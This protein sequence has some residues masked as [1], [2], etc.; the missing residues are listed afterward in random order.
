MRLDR[1]DAQLLRAVAVLF[2]AYLAMAVFAQAWQAI[3]QI[4]DVILI[5]IAAWALSYLLTPLVHWLDTRTVLDL[6]LSVVLVYIGIAIVLAAGGALLVPALSAQLTDLANRAPEYGDRAAQAVIALQRQLDSMGVHADITDLYGSLPVRVGE[7]AA[8]YASN[9]VGVISATAGAL[10]NV[11]L[12]LIIAFLMLIDGGA[13]WQ[14]FTA[15][16]PDGRRAEAELLRESADRS[17]GGF[18]RGS[19]LLGTIYGVATFVI[20]AIFGVP[21]AVVLAIVSGLTMIIPFFGPIIAMIPVFAVTALAATDALVWVF[22]LTL[23]LQQIVLNVISPRVMSHNIGIHPIFV[24][25]ALLLGARLAGFWGVVLAMPLAGI[26][27][28][29]AR[30]LWAALTS[31]GDDGGASEPA[32][33]TT[34]L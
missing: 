25:L 23:V 1:R 13:L 4:G 18:I 9:V 2:A 17:F 14:R 32:A 30:Y 15:A 19:L 6:T 5:F 31:N 11:T 20:L 8:S 34:T 21:F 10:F 33:D 27:N 3:A 26:I 16:L 28:T 29:F 12:V 22:V 24:F 7:I